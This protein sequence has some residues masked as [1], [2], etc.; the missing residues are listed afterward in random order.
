M[1]IVESLEIEK[2]WKNTR[3]TQ[4]ITTVDNCFVVFLFIL[5]CMHM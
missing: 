2:E 3:P 1:V 5:K 4:N